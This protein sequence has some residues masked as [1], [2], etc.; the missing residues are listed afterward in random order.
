MTESAR[1]NLQSQPYQFSNKTS[2]SDEY[3]RVSGYSEGQFNNQLAILGSLTN[4]IRQGKYTG[5]IGKPSKSV[6]IG[7]SFGTVLTHALIAAYPRISDGVILTGVGYNATAF[8]FPGFFESA[9]LNIANTVWPGKFP[10]LDSGYLA[11]ADVIGNAASFFA[12]NYDKEVLWY[13]QDIVQPPAI[14]E[15]ITGQPTM[16]PELGV[17]NFTAP[18]SISEIS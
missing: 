18:V 4:S 10:G 3:L 14:I 16:L 11:F 13:S 1:V 5:T 15:F 12:G 6:H 2:N 9:R 8:D 17:L 7:H